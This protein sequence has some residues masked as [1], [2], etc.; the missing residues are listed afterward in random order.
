MPYMKVN[1]TRKQTLE[2]A[3]YGLEIIFKSRLTRDLLNRKSRIFKQQHDSTAIDV[4]KLAGS[5]ERKNKEKNVKT[6]F[7]IKT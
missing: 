5:A 4:H 2:S 1:K 7:I 6:S 3:Q